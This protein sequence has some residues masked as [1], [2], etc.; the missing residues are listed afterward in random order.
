MRFENS[1]KGTKMLNTSS[2]KA[3]LNKKYL[4]LEC[5]GSQNGKIKIL[6]YKSNDA[7]KEYEIITELNLFEYL[8]KHYKS[9]FAL[10]FVDKLQI[11]HLL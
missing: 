7:D 2:F 8:K 9:I 1:I 5:S 3:R 10:L 6:T 11:H 4:V